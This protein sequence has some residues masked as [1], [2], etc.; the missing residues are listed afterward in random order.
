MP[1]AAAE[2]HEPIGELTISTIYQDVKPLATTHQGFELTT[3]PTSSPVV[4]GPLRQFLLHRH[5][6]LSPAA[7]TATLAGS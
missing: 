2:L 5:F 7:V 1:E 3:R 4:L 6:V